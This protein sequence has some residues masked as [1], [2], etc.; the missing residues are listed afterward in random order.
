MSLNNRIADEELTGRD[1]KGNSRGLI[2]GTIS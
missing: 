2:H 1:L